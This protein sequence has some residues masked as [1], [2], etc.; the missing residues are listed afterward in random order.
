MASAIILCTVG[1]TS[2]DD[3]NEW[4]RKEHAVRK[5]ASSE[6]FSKTKKENGII[7]LSVTSFECFNVY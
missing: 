5:W 7:F 1:V 3:G 6:F 2:P 4:E